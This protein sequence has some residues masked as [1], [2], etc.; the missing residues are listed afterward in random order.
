M[1]SANKST[2][3]SPVRAKDVFDEFKKKLK[4]IYILLVPLQDCFNNV[5]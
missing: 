2:N 3:I 4:Y 5:C 1:P